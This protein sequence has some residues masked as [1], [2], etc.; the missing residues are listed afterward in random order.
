MIK[1]H[2]KRL[3]AERNMRVS[4]LPYAARVS[5]NTV[6]D[7]CN[8]RIKGIQLATVERICEALDC[9]VGDLFEYVPDERHPESAR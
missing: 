9:S 7:I 1:I 8:R 6:S 2:L 4:D 5:K 3:L